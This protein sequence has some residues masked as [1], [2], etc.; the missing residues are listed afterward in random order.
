MFG[1]G[2][3]VAE[4]RNPPPNDRAWSVIR[5][6]LMASARSTVLKG[7]TEIWAVTALLASMRA[8]SHSA[9]S[10]SRTSRAM[11]SGGSSGAALR[12][13]SALVATSTVY[14]RSAVHRPRPHVCS[15][16]SRPATR[17]CANGPPSDHTVALGP[18][19]RR[20]CSYV[21]IDGLPDSVRC[22]GLAG[23]SSLS[24]HP[25]VRE[26]NTSPLLEQVSPAA[27]MAGTCFSS[28]YEHPG[29]Q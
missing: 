15:V 10:E 17:T 16:T 14:P 9:G 21:A 28:A 24:G 1:A 18:G 8:T 3:H 26:R 12:P 29:S 20:G 22:M 5:T 27:R 2:D 4:P 25:D 7:T 6:E 19:S 11:Q 13:L 23:R